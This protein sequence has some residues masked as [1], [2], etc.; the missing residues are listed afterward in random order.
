MQIVTAQTSYNPGDTVHGLIFMT[1]EVSFLRPCINLKATGEESVAMTTTFIG[2]VSREK[3]DD[4]HDECTEC[5]NLARQ[6]N[7]VLE[8]EAMIYRRD[9]GLEAGDY[10]IQF[11][12][13]LPTDLPSTVDFDES[14]SSDL[15]KLKTSYTITASLRNLL[16]KSGKLMD[17][18]HKIVINQL[19]DQQ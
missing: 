11:E 1:T 17:Y 15:P 12:F 7:Q 2:K 6:T 3:G 9:D 14:D 10:S 18:E 4:M 13:T 8:I 16:D 5:R 19:P